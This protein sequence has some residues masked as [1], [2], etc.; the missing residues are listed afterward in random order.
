MEEKAPPG[1]GAVG[2]NGAYLQPMNRP[3]ILAEATWKQVRAEKYEIAVIPWGATEAHNYHLPYGTDTMQCDHVYGEA[4]RLA[5]EAGAKVML[6]PTVPFGIQTGQLDIPFCIN[7]NPSTQMAMLD[8]IIRGLRG[9]GIERIVIANG[10]GG[11]EFRGLVRELNARHDVFLSLIPNWVNVLPQEA[12]FVDMGDHA[13]ELETSA[14][15][16]IAPEL[17]HLEDAGD[18]AERKPRLEAMQKKWAWSPRAW[19]QVTADTGIGDP[20]RATADKG[21]R[22]I[23][24]VT[25]EIAGYLVQLAEIDRRDL[26]EDA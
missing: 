2:Q 10:H 19:T 3:Y 17:V 16:H 12:Y 15:M 21:A 22:F 6:L 9:Q 11:N 5:W 23:A 7:L 4:A 8:D 25:R 13:G 26:Y 14:M 20:T 24:D 18:G 1:V